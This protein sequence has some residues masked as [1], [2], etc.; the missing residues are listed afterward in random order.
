MLA[1]NAWRGSFQLMRAQALPVVS[2]ARTFA[3]VKNE[4]PASMSHEAMEKD[5]RYHSDA[6]IPENVLASYASDEVFSPGF[7]I[8]GEAREGRPIYL[9]LQSTTP[10]DPRVT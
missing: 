3:A 6:D 7:S 2:A 5:K 8:K 9:D 4:A 10:I 1:R